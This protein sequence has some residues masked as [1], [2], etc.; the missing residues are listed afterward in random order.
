M[1]KVIEFRVYRVESGNHI[2]DGMENGAQ[3]LE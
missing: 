1:S 2:E 3:G